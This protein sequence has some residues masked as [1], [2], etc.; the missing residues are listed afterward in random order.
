MEYVSSDTNV[1]IDFQVISRLQLPF[2]LPYT[3]LMYKESMDSELL[4]PSELRNDLV[5]AGLVGVDID[6]EEFA[7]ADSWG[8]T[9]PRI[10]IQDRIAL[11]IAKQRG[12]ILL[13]G[14]KALRTSAMQEHVPVIGTLGILDAC[15]KGNFI[16]VAEYTYCLKSL[17]AHNGGEVRLPPQELTKRIES[18]AHEEEKIIALQSMVHNAI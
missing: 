10:S 6:Y 5:E 1:W 2:L 3:Y 8:E 18:L 13:T 11:A 14:D 16:S 12:I 17:Q 4:Y 9:Y 15:Y 7:L